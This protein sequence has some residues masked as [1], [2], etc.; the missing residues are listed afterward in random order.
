M[1]VDADVAVAADAL[2][3]L[4]RA[5]ASDPAL[6]AVFGSYDD[7][8]AARGLVSRFRNLLHHHVHQSSP[9]PATTFWSGLGAV[10]RRDFERL[11]GFD[12]RRYGHASIEDVELG[13]RLV[14]AGG[15]VA[16]D[17]TAQGKHLKRWTLA[18]MVATDFARR[19]VPW[20]RLLLRSGTG[21]AALNLG[22][23]HRLSAV[24]CVIG[25]AAAGARAPS[26]A[27]GA[28]GLLLWLNR[29]FYALLVR[30]SGARG[31]VGGLALHAVHHLTAV[32]AVPAGIAAHAGERL[33][34]AIWHG[35]QAHGG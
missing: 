20:V 9:G 18:D 13:A 28:L 12:A 7:A 25:A 33:G 15:R 32:A 14:A 19:G 35:R 22:R 3:R 26:V 34:Q 4:R 17:P 1:F 2:A 30:R 21:S 8:P 6:T 11:G 5:L 23:R 31:L 29:S 27:A 24:T 16:L 10:R